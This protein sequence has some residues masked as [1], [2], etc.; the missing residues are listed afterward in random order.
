MCCRIGV[1]ASFPAI[2]MCVI[3]GQDKQCDDGTY[4]RAGRVKR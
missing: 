3:V 1:E 4:G 2:G